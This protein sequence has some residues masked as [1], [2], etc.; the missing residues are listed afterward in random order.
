MSFGCTLGKC[1]KALDL[2]ADNL[3]LR[4]ARSNLFIMN[5]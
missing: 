5:T 2:T 3:L 1:M 4:A